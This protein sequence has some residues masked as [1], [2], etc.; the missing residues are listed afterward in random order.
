M[1]GEEGAVEP[2]VSPMAKVHL[3]EG[4]MLLLD[5]MTTHSGSPCHAAQHR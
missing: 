3:G 4:D 1:K 2:T 5:P